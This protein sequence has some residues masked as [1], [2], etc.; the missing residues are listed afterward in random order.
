MADTKSKK[1]G[2]A[3]PAP[4]KGAKAE[5][6]SPKSPR[7]TAKAPAPMQKPTK[8]TPVLFKKKKEGPGDEGEQGEK[9][10]QKPTKATPVLFDKRKKKE[11]SGDED[12][13]GE[14]PMQKPTK[15]TPVLFDKR[16]KEGS[17]D[18]DEQGEKP[19]QRPTKA[20]PVLFDK[21]KKGGSGD[22]DEQGE[23]P[24]QK[25]TKATPVLYGKKKESG[26]EDEQ[27]EKPMQRPTKATPVLFDKKKE[28][29]DEDE[30]GKKPMQRPTKATPVLFDKKKEQGEKP[31]APRGPRKPDETTEPFAAPFTE[32]P[33][34]PVDAAPE[35]PSAASSRPRKV[36]VTAF[37]RKARPP[38]AD[39]IADAPTPPPRA[40]P[41][42]EP[43]PSKAKPPPAPAATAAP[44]PARAPER[45]SPSA[46]PT[47]RWTE[48]SDVLVEGF[49]LTPEPRFRRTITEPIAEGFFVARVAGEGSARRH[50]LT[51]RPGAASPGGLDE[52]LGE[53]PVSYGEDDVL[54]LPRDP[55][56][57]FFFWDFK[58]TQAPGGRAV[59]RVYDGDQLIREVDFT[60]EQRSF[61]LHDLPAGRTYR[62]EAHL[63]DASGAT[64]LMGQ[65]KLVSL[66]GE[67]AV[68]TTEVRFL[69]LPWHLALAKLRDYLK[70]GRAQ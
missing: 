1:G 42:P 66:P 59:L 28:S 48:A 40:K 32:S 11:G 26:D 70:E 55:H 15:A 6:A 16:K 53:L 37:P 69:K 29:D 58:S 21:R 51:D 44:A 2:K 10:M 52:D 60:P 17:G 45:P 65:A 13:Q 20:T 3:A 23:K 62:L 50:G 35:D 19:M 4:K 12:E 9:P 30:Q 38:T 8:A 36:D 18:E 27:G 5:K 33:P 7:R 56:S 63:V 67:G 47:S 31:A 22:E 68:R 46:E 64:R 14:K 61:Y 25:P 34:P 43:A 49:F 54:A 24:M 41:E 57:F 39:R